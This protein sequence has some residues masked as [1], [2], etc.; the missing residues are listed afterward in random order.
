MLPLCVRLA[1]APWT[2]PAFTPASHPSLL[3]L[4]DDCGTTC[5]TAPCSSVEATSNSVSKKMNNNGTKKTAR[6]AVQ[7][8]APVMAKSVKAEKDGRNGCCAIVNNVC[9]PSGNACEQSGMACSCDPSQ[10]SA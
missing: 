1:N 10:C 3:V 4:L 8:A 9:C 6:A 7:H 5:S 2:L